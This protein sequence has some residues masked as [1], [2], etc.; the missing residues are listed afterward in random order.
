MLRPAF[1]PSLR[2]NKLPFCLCT[3][4]VCIPSASR[5]APQ[6][7]QAVEPALAACVEEGSREAQGQGCREEPSPGLGSPGGAEAEELGPAP[8][9]GVAPLLQ[10]CSEGCGPRHH[11]RGEVG[12]KT[13]GPG[14]G[15]SSLC[16][17]KV[18]HSRLCA[19]RV[20]KRK[21]GKDLPNDLLTWET[22]FLLQ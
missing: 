8:G 19:Q 4:L 7:P 16:A 14:W 13:R 1:P 10:G 5:R 3:C 12:M 15:E 21:T 17:G 18:P 20:I 22:Q 2:W 9:P 11:S 6:R